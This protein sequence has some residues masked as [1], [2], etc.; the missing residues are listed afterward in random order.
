MKE[1]YYTVAEH[2]FCLRMTEDEPLWFS[3]ATAY[4]PFRIKIS[5]SLIPLFILTVYDLTSL[6]QH[7]AEPFL[8]EQTGVDG[9]L[10]RYY[11]SAGY[12]WFEDFSPAG[13][14]NGVLRVNREMKSAVL[15]A[16]TDPVRRRLM[17]DYGMMLMYILNTICLDTVVMHAS[18]VVNDGKGYLLLGKSGTGKSTHCNLWKRYVPGS[19]CLNDDH[20]VVR[21]VGD[22]PMVYGSP[23][24]GKTACYRNWS[25]PVNG[26]IRL[27]QSHRNHIC[28]LVPLEAYASLS[29]G[30]AAMTWNE[31]HADA[32]DCII[33]YLVQ[34]ISC[35]LLECLPDKAAACLCADTVRKEAQICRNG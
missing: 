32:K 18:V 23:W 30:S 15:Y 21:L 11:Q 22:V 34:K 4:A 31:D 33:Q 8:L 25:V 27:R 29:A 10:F 12:H 7:P 3:L 9:N 35:W 5:D 16:C 13:E 24:S 1:Q 28:R 17:T 20:P 19:D 14:L 2:T 6:T 26:F